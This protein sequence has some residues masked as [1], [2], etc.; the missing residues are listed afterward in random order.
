MESTELREMKRRLN[1]KAGD[2]VEVR[3]RQEILATLDKQG[4]LDNLPFMPQMFQ[5]CGQRLRVFKRAHKTCDT[6][7]PVRGRRVADAVHLDTRCDGQAYGGCQAGCL[8]F[9]KEAWL[10][11]VDGEKAGQA[12]PGTP[13][14]G[15]AVAGVG[16][17]G[18]TEQDVLAGTLAPGQKDAQDPAYVCQAT[19]LPHFTTQLSW[20]DVR[21]YVEDWTSGNASLWRILKGFI[22]SAYYKLSIAGIGVGRIQRWLYDT[23]CPLWGGTPYPRKVGSLPLG[24]AT[25]NETLN[26]QPGELVRVKSHADILRTL[27]VENKNRGLY[28]DA[29]MVPFCGRTYRV[30]RRVNNI[31]D[32]K[33]GKMMRMKSASII[34][35]G[36]YC[37]SRFSECRL[38][39]PRAIYSFWREIWLERVSAD[40]A[41]GGAGEEL[42]SP[43]NHG[44]PLQR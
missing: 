30:L 38:F 23:F 44:N 18:C 17:P 41:A 3:S 36:V 29:E 31:L 5:Y 1:L 42:P 12:K 14:S 34:L 28:F 37:Q 32:E 8:I 27:N 9:W 4:R 10:K 7:F 26:L 33:T 21:Q 35:E 25:P 15:Q 24:Q 13:A 2:L 39:C 11:K 19:L 16:G 20:W 43:G 40:A 6:V 22:Y